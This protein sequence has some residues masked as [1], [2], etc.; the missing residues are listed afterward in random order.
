MRKRLTWHQKELVKGALSGLLIL[1]A[2]VLWNLFSGGDVHSD[3]TL[4]DPPGQ[5]DP[6]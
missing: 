1:G 2:L 5:L 4:D 6:R 3:P